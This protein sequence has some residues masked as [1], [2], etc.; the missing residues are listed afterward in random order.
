M[1]DQSGGRK[2]LAPLTREDYEDGIPWAIDPAYLTVSDSSESS[3]EVE[4]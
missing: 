1:V 3:R 4:N 2:P